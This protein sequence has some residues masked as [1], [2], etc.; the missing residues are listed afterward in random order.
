MRNMNDDGSSVQ[1]IGTDTFSID[2]G[3]DAGYEGHRVL[4][5]GGKWALECLANLE[6]LPARGARIF[7]G[8]PK[9][10]R[11]SG[12]PARVIAWIPRARGPV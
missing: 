12:G 4:S 10:E 7:I 9:V 6:H 11:A 2:R 5:T 3:R 8:A 1:R